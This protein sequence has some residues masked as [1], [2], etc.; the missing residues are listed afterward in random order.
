MKIKNILLALAVAVLGMSCDQFLDVEPIGKVIPKSY[1]EYRALITDAYNG[2]PFD[3][4]YSALL[5]DESKFVTDEVSYIQ[6]FKDVFIWNV[7]SPDANTRQLPWQAFYKIIFYANHIV[8]DRATIIDGTTDQVNQLVGEAFLLRAYMYFNLVNLYADHYGVSDPNTQRGIPLSFL[9]VD[10]EKRNKPSTVAEVYTQIL[11]DIN[12]GTALLTVAEQPKGYNY[13]F[14]KISAYGFAARVYL[15]MGDFAKA[16]EFAQKALAINGKLEDLNS[17]TAIMPYKFKS[18]ESILAFE[19]TFTLDNA[20]SLVASSSLVG[21]YTKDKD[22][23]LTAFYRLSYG[24]YKV[25]LGG[26][27]DAK[28]GMRT[29]EFYLIVAEATARSNGDLT[30]AKDAVKTLLKNRLKPDYYTQRAAEIDG[31]GRVELVKAIFDERAR[32]LAFQGFRWF[33]LKRNGKPEIVKMYDGQTHTLKQNDP[34]YVVRFPKDAI[35]NNPYL[36]E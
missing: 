8:K 10:L 17:A 9:D 3:R 26:G 22:L 1:N 12:E 14:S 18:V 6:E 35:A 29:A 24:D 23:R 4:S 20:S 19:Q 27:D 30:K 11:S 33:D 13:R 15:Y 5:S 21:L 2:K 25:K 34:R 31:M 36:A 32:E 7:A 16:E 28:L